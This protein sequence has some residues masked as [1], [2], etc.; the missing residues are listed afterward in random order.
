MRPVAHDQM[1]MGARLWG[2]TWFL[3]TLKALRDLVELLE[4]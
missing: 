4:L 3:R 2:P 1:K